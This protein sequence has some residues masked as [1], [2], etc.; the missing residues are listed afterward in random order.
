MES[1]WPVS[2]LSTESVGSR[3]ELVA[4]S[5][6]TPSRPR[7][8]DAT[9]HLSLVGVGACVFGITQLYLLQLLLLT[10]LT[11]QSK[12]AC[13]S[14]V[15]RSHIPGRNQGCG[16]DSTTIADIPTSSLTL[17]SHSTVQH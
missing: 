15:Y 11:D 14:D 6:H 9:R 5:V 13:V 12:I 4:N 3:R 8:R 16:F 2:K 10:L 17:F 1:V 7:R